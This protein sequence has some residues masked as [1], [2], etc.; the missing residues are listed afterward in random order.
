MAPA[1]KVPR[2]AT[3][4]RAV[5]P[6]KLAHT[7]AGRPSYANFPVRRRLRHDHHRGGAALAPRSRPTRPRGRSL[8]RALE[9]GLPSRARLGI[10]TGMPS[11]PPTKP[12]PPADMD[13]AEDQQ[14]DS[15]EGTS[16]MEDV[17]SLRALDRWVSDF[18][19]RY[20]VSE[21]T[22]DSLRAIMLLAALVQAAS[23][24]AGLVLVWHAIGCGLSQH[25]GH[26]MVCTFGV[27]IAIASFDIAAKTRSRV[28][29]ARVETSRR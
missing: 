23:A 13:Y 15:A 22:A 7:I 21:P 2:S 10:V 4:T 1:D 3:T 26:S 19:D 16:V 28:Q 24:T 8:R 27:F 9:A 18:I 29:S 6:R 11:N 20:F 14:A 12:P 25:H 17:P 5:S